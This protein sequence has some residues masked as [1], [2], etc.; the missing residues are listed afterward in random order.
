MFF[1]S[2]TPDDSLSRLDVF[3]VHIDQMNVAHCLNQMCFFIFSGQACEKDADC[4][5]A[6]PCCSGL[7]AFRLSIEKHNRIVF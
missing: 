1:S 2:Y 5:E 7:V 6:E 4:G 3:F